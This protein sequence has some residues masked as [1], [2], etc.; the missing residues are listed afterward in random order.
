MTNPTSATHR[1]FQQITGDGT[2]TAGGCPHD[3]NGLILGAEYTNRLTGD[4]WKLQ[5]LLGQPIGQRA[6]WDWRKCCAEA[7][8]TGP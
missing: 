4:V 5:E 1:R 3:G 2:P 6:F 7:D 8:P